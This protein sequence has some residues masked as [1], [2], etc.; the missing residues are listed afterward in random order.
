MKA[1]TTALIVALG[2][3]LLIATLMLIVHGEKNNTSKEYI[4]RI[5]VSSYSSKED[6]DLTSAFA[7]GAFDLSTYHEAQ[8]FVQKRIENKI[9]FSDFSQ[10][11]IYATEEKVSKSDK[12]IKVADLQ[13]KN[14]IQQYIL[15]AAEDKR[16]IYSVAAFSQ[17][18]STILKGTLITVTPKFNEDGRVKGKMNQGRQIF[19]P[20]F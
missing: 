6:I 18:D 2:C 11:D 20:N 14:G 5:D 9:R 17:G 1:K 3:C 16:V 12:L 19:I 10:K 15:Y 13:D 4:K 8:Q 7:A